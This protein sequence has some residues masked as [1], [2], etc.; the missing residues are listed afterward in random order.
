MTVDKLINIEFVYSFFILTLLSGLY[1]K[2]WGI[3][4]I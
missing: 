2:C 1:N 4:T 3:G